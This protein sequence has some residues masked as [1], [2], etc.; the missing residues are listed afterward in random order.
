MRLKVRP[1]AAGGDP[2]AADFLVH[3]AGPWRGQAERAWIEPGQTSD[4]ECNS[5]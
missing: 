5:N 1:M 2:S 4:A 3:C